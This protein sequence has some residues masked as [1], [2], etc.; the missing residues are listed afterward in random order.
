MRYVKKPV[1]NSSVC[2]LSLLIVC[3]A[4]FSC[5]STNKIVGTSESPK[6]FK[7]GHR[8]TRGLMPENTIPAMERGIAEGANTIEMDVHVTKDGQVLVYHDASFNPDYTSMPDGSDIQKDQRQQHIFYQS[9]YS[10]IRK[11]VIGKKE[12]PAFPQQQRLSTYAPLLSE[13]IDSVEAFTKAHSLPGV[14]YLIEVKSSERT[15]GIEQPAP[16]EFM[17]ILMAVLNPKNLGNRLFIQ[18]F[19]MRPLQVLHREYPEIKLGFLTDNKQASFEENIARLGFNPT[20]YNP[21]Y[22]L[23]NT[24]LVH[25]CHAGNMM[26]EPWTVNSFDDMKRMKALGVDGIITDYPN[27]FKELQASN[28]K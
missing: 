7:V 8:G 11:F 26:I 5:K 17:K 13:L 2:F 23:V 27:L 6:F 16:G 14:Y 1:I 3:S 28:L 4:F 12:Y 21:N 18:S 10:D 9:N 20:F 22:S 15:D 25:K 19:D 24:E